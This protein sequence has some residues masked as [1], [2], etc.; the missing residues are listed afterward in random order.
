M[1]IKLFVER[2]AAIDEFSAHYYGDK[3]SHGA[4]GLFMPNGFCIVGVQWLP[5]HTP[6]VALIVCNIAVGLWN[7][8]D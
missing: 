6:N 7:D 3:L 1:S 4:L 8:P 5:H 2:D